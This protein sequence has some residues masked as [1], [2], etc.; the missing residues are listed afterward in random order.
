MH[1]NLVAAISAAMTR[2]QI[3]R[4]PRQEISSYD[5]CDTETMKCHATL[6]DEGQ[7]K[8]ACRNRNARAVALAVA[9]WITTNNDNL[10]SAIGQ[11]LIDKFPHY[12]ARTPEDIAIAALSALAAKMQEMGEGG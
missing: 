9:E 7:A 4:N 10:A 3:Y 1:P 2:F 11:A 12:I 6:P 5:V 8:A